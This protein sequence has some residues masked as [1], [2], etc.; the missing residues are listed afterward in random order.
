MLAGGPAGG[1]LSPGDHEGGGAVGKLP[2]TV[3]EA[4]MH[5]RPKTPTATT[6]PANKFGSL[7][8][9]YD[10]RKHHGKEPSVSGFG[11]GFEGR[12]AD[13]VSVM[14]GAF[15]SMSVSNASISGMSVNTGTATLL[16][17]S[18]TT[19]TGT[20]GLRKPKVKHVRRKSLVEQAMQ[21][22]GLGGSSSS[23]SEPPPPV[24]PLPPQHQHQHHNHATVR[25]FDGVDAMGPQK[26]EEYA[27]AVGSVGEGIGADGIQ[28]PIT[29][30]NRPTHGRRKSL[31]DSIKNFVLPTSSPSSISSSSPP[32]PPVP[33][34]PMPLL[35]SSSSTHSQNQTYYGDSD[36][37]SPNVHINGLPY[38]DTVPPSS[39][40]SV[41]SPLL[42][43]PPMMTVRTKRSDM[44]MRSFATNGSIGVSAPSP[45]ND[46]LSATYS[47]PA[48]P[49]AHSISGGASGG[50]TVVKKRSGLT[51]SPSGSTISSASSSRKGILPSFRM[52]EGKWGFRSSSSSAAHNNHLTSSGTAASSPNP[53]QQQQ[54]QQIDD[55]NLLRRLQKME[56]FE[57]LIAVGGSQFKTKVVTLSS[58]D[59]PDGLS[60]SSRK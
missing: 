44:S 34:V 36:R 35:N 30:P 52:G 11:G 38:V 17:N 15:E 8:R 60:L 54:Q 27:P 28:V 12:A 21:V 20:G 51:R 14:S 42:S 47:P 16:S 7:S 33:S 1:P 45:G 4:L 13:E 6:G 18:G 22:L 26:S 40:A 46:T 32:P 2:S 48:S 9:S 59:D 41:T 50:R 57:R 10:G 31:V 55:A 25:A 5:S 19:V 58:A 37:D 23:N 49:S 24:P 53:A 43:T 3:D 39:S 56:E 29:K